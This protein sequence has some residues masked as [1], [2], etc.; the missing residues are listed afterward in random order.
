VTATGCHLHVGSETNHKNLKPEQAKAQPGSELP[1]P[2]S[3]SLPVPVSIMIMHG[4]GRSGWHCHWQWHAVPVTPSPS[5][6]TT[7]TQAASL[8]GMPATEL[9][10]CGTDSLPVTASF[11]LPVRQAD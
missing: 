4:T 6:R 5:R 2:V 7:G 9:T 3:L 10:H 1:V 8:S 11:K